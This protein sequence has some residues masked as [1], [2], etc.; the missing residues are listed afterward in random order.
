MS[1]RIGIFSDP[2][3]HPEPA[4]EALQIFESE[5]VSQILCAGDIGGYGD[6]LDETITLLQQH[7]V[8]AIRGNHEEW[9]LQQEDFAGSAA[10]R[11]YFSSLPDHLSLTIEGVSLYM[12]HA[13]PPD[14]IEKGLRLFDQKGEVVP[15]VLAEWHHRLSDF[16]YDVLVLGHTHQAYD[17][18]LVNTL[19]INPGSTVFN[20]SCVVLTLPQRTVEWYGLSGK[21][22]ERVWH[23]G[24]NQ[25]PQG[26]G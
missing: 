19:V 9:A 14:R 3:A 4:A 23:W 25:L 22:I 20:H 8:R 12:V 18:K 24:S 26:K 7:Q 16:A 10:S 15:A 2:H 13:E 11:N 5:G 6:R 17:V 21:E 1:T